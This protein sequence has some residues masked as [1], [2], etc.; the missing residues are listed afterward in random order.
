MSTTASVNVQLGGLMV[1][2]SA[3]VAGPDA[4]LPEQ[5]RRIGGPRLVAPAD[6]GTLRAAR[7]IG[8]ATLRRAA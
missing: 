6:N 4:A 3:A 5:L 8:G 1:A 2:S 7:R